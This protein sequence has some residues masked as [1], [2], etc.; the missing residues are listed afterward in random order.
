LPPVILCV[1]DDPNALFVRRLLLSI[2]GYEV[3]TASSVET[4]QGLFACNHVDL[5]ITDHLLPDGTGAELVLQMK[6][7]QPKASVVL[8]TAWA[9]TPPGYDRADRLLNKGVTPEDFL[10]EVASLLSNHNDD[11]RHSRTSTPAP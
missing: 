2:A 10:R 6:R 11:P 7:V 3:L 8:L 5:M 9:E 4:A 1:D